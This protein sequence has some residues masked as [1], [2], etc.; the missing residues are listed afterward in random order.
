MSE[1]AK[2]FAKLFERTRKRIEYFVQGAII[3]FTESVVMRM[4]E[5]GVSKSDL[6]TRL[7][8]KPSYITK[9]LRGGTNFTLDSMVRIALVLDSELSIKLVPKLSHEKWSDVFQSENVFQSKLL[10]A[11]RVLLS[12]WTATRESTF[13]FKTSSSQL[14]TEKVSDEFIFSIA[15]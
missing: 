12:K 3:E 6:A 5:L 15:A 14:P 2:R 9:V 4:R 7:K 8:C 10:K 11:E 13:Q 1:T